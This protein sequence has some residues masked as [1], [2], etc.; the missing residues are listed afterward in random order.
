MAARPFPV[1]G[2]QR[3][4][5]PKN[6]WSKFVLI[7]AKI[8]RALFLRA[9][10]LA[11]LKVN[12][13]LV[14]SRPRASAGKLESINSGALANGVIRRLHVLLFTTSL[15]QKS[16]RQV[17]YQDYKSMA[18][19]KYRKPG[20]SGWGL[21]ST[22]RYTPRRGGYKRKPARATRRAYRRP[23]RP[24]YRRRL[25]K[26]AG[27]RQPGHT[28]VILRAT[29]DIATTFTRTGAVTGYTP[30]QF[31]FGADL[32]STNVP[33]LPDD[34]DIPPLVLARFNEAAAQ[35]LVWIRVYLKDTYLQ[36]Q[37]D[38]PEDVRDAYV[39]ENSIYTHY[40]Q[41]N[42]TAITAMDNQFFANTGY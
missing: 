16:S 14:T 19:R 30:E 5:R 33:W 23:Q 25:N 7:G 15:C 27:N 40:N 26:N 24:V 29:S 9:F 32:P 2:A 41:Y 37:I 18:F 34:N 38:F 35:R 31:T 17:Y 6:A 11:H 10:I 39:G 3:L 20:F 12:T 1:R 36:S 4:P 13:S 28:D 22:Y 42:P 21:R 8:F